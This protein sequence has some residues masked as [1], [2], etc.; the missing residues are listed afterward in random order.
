M[1]IPVRCFT[2]GKVIAHEWE[3]YLTLINHHT[4]NEALELI[5]FNT[6]CCRRMFLSHVDIAKQLILVSNNKDGPPQQKNLS[7]SAI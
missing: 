7:T 5:E 3:K 2:C 1:L 4:K 6:F